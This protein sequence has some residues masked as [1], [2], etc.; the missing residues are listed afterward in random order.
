[1]GVALC[2]R[3]G[4]RFLPAQLRSILG[5]TLPVA[6][7]VLS[8]DASS[9]GTVEL[10]RSIL[11]E[12]G[13]GGPALT[14]LRNDPP[15]GVTANFEQALR[16]SSA[17]L[18][19]LCDQDDVWR[20]EHVRRLASRFQARPGL[21]LAGSDA[22]AIDAQGRPLGF[23]LFAGLEISETE[24]RELR[25]GRGY[26]ALLR[27]NLFTGATT[28]LRRSLLELALPIPVSW[29]HDEWLAVIAA[30]AGEVELLPEVLTDYRQH[31]ANQIGV[32]RQRLR[33]KLRKLV[34]PRTERNARLLA[35]AAALVPVLESL[36]RQGSATPQQVEKARRK[37]AHERMRSALPAQ[38]LRRL[39]PVLRE[40]RSGAY[41]RYDYGLAD[42]ARDLIQPL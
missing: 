7:I 2:T 36:Q 14:V 29:V 21:L 22:A 11:A 25:A 5:Q 18:I 19:A 3:D 16:A 33:G 6:E 9:D 39:G 41:S 1:M 13:P 26:D 40:L 28:M 15:L 35:R 20:P 38:R 8:D 34:L 37:L 24:W 32:Q 27:R 31:G 12:A 23:T 42:A 4:A 10:A 30:V 17:P